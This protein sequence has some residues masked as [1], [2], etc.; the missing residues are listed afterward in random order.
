MVPNQIQVQVPCDC[1]SGRGIFA[2]CF[3][4]FTSTLRGLRVIILC[5]NDYLQFKQ[6]S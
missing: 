2:R 5:F 3:I 1:V 4:Y 6:V